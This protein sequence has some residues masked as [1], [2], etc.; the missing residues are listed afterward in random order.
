MT[1]D[2]PQIHYQDDAFMIMQKPSGWIVNEASTTSNQPVIQTWLKE[3]QDFPLVH[4]LEFRSG[5]V[6][7]L[8]KETSG[9]LVIAKTEQAFANIQS[10]FKERIVKKTY[11]ALVHEYVEPREGVIDV[12]VGRLPW[13]RDRFGVLLG[14]RSSLTRYQ[15]ID[16]YGKGNQK[17]TYLEL[18]PETGRTHQ[19]R[20]HMKHLNR[21]LVAD[22]FY[23]G[24][25]TARNDRKWC[26][27]LF[28]HAYSI[29]FTHS[30]TGETVSF[31]VPLAPDL[32]RVLSSLT[33]LT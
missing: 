7:R 31:Q 10:Q 3:T 4:S 20:I 21:P 15:T 11:R 14:G 26:P 22:E 27:R 18:Y 29:Q 5:I 33:R 23:A 32:D 12:P 24:R 13:R 25:K 19:I 9:A 16:R 28:L 2:K 30:S 8:D 1:I 17:F 6:H